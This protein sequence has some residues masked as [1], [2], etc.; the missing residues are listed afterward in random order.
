MYRLRLNVRLGS[1]DSSYFL[2][3][4]YLPVF[5]IVPF[6]PGWAT[7]LSGFVCVISFSG[8]GSRLRGWVGSEPNL[9]LGVR[10]RSVEGLICWH[11]G[12]LSEGLG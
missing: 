10:P 6:P 1:G 9:G 4:S 7:E 5:Q 3:S 8:F 11:G 12:D 2:G